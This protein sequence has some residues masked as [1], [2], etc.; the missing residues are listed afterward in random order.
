MLLLS[1]I[2][3]SPSNADFS[4]VLCHIYFG[5]NHVS[6][7]LGVSNKLRPYI[8]IDIFEVFSILVLV[9]LTFSDLLHITRI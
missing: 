4:K 1:F 5:V 9:Y 3:I 2:L 8:R 7:T 6:Q